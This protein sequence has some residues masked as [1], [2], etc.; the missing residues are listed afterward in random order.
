[1]SADEFDPMIERLFA[2]T[3]HLAD[4]PLFAAGV[5]TKLQSST[6]M[7]TL[8]L[9][10]AGVVGGIIAVRESMNLDLQLTDPQAPVAGRVIGQS[11]QSA[12][13]DVQGAVAS[14]LSQMGLADVTLGSMG[15]MQL[16]WITAGALIALAAAGVVKL[17]QEV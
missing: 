2:R 15:G 7:R 10:L 16:F 1:M 12:S 14:G 5:E 13:L 11:L 4:A 6:R 8:A 3:P 17:S 9:T